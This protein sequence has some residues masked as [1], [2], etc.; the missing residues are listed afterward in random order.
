MLLSWENPTDV[1]LGKWRTVNVRR[2][3]TGTAP[4]LLVAQD[5]PW[6]VAED[7][8]NDDPSAVYAVEYCDPTGA[9]AATLVDHRI[10]RYVRP[11]NIC[12]VRLEF[13]RPDGRPESCKPVEV[14]DEQKVGEFVKRVCTNYKGQATLF[15]MPGQR[16]LLR[17]EGEL[18]ALDFVVPD[19]RVATWDDIL[20]N[21]SLIDT[22]RRGWY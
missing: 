7:P 10:A 8:E 2:S 16:L 14:S 21:G 18:K 13:I 3:M 20:K 5:V 9:V 1:Y 11:F 4:N 6:G 19:I 12:E 22:D 17:R 15:L